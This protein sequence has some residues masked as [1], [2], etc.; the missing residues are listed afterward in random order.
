MTVG[1]V[2]SLVS[3]TQVKGLMI[4][5]TLADYFDFLNLKGFKRV[6]EYRYFE[7]SLN[8]RRTSRYFI[9]HFNKLVPQ[10][11]RI[12][13]VQDEIIPGN[14][15][16]ASKGQVDSNTKR[17]G[18]RSGFEYWVNWERSAKEIYQRMFKEL[19][20]I[21]EVAAAQFISHYVED[22]DKELKCAER[23]HFDLYSTNYDLPFIVQWQDPLHEEYKGKINCLHFDS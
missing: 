4:H 1:E 21:N 16:G 2:F 19:M 15:Y 3:N 9:N 14:W 10:G 23:L 5:N 13:N 20:N 11:D 6:H 12:A 22:V 18:I 17:N 8:Q 7:E